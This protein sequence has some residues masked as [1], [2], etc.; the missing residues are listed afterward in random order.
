MT[1]P[2]S[3][4]TIQ[5]FNQ[6]IGDPAD[7]VWEKEYT[8]QTSAGG[9]YP[10]SG[11]SMWWTI[12]RN[13]GTPAILQLTETN[14]I[15]IDTELGTATI[16]ILRSQTSALTTSIEEQEAVYDFDLKNQNGRLLRIVKGTITFE[17]DVS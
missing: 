8:I 12:R 17:G 7:I 9:V 4:I 5:L 3:A 16:Q 2:V 15:T 13:Y 10:L 14:G 1:T 6:S 11:A